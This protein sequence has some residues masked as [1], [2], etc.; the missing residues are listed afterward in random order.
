MLMADEQPISQASKGKEISS[1]LKS[2]I[3]ILRQQSGGSVAVPLEIAISVS[4]AYRDRYELR[5]EVLGWGIVIARLRIQAV[6]SF[7]NS[8]RHPYPSV[9]APSVRGGGC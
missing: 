2:D 9:H 1:R 8:D 7:A 5:A 6:G 3:A 4:D